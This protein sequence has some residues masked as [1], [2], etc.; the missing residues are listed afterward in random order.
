MKLLCLQ[1][2]GPL[3]KAIRAQTD[4]ELEEITRQMKAGLAIFEE[5]LQR[6]GKKF[7]FSAERPGLMDYSIWPWFERLPAF[8]NVAPAGVMADTPRLAS[9][10]LKQWLVTV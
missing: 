4:E 2:Y 6:R 7:F 10:Q 5:E 1:F 8:E 3:H 9:S